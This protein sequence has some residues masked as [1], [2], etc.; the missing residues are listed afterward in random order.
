MSA[1][2]WPWPNLRLRLTDPEAQNKMRL[3]FPH[4]IRFTNSGNCG[5][6][7]YIEKSTINKIL[8]ASCNQFSLFRGR[9]NDLRTDSG[10]F[11]VIVFVLCGIFS[12]LPTFS[13]GSLIF[14]FFSTIAFFLLP[15]LFSFS[16][17]FFLFFFFSSKK[18]YKKMHWFVECYT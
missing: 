5:T 8:F 15:I 7:I 17:L 10:F 14:W 1:D 3:G 9:M 11:K 12:C 6:R 18:K 16:I 2:D 13:G 4:F